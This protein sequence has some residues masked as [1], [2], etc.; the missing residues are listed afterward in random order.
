MF[1]SARYYRPSPPLRGFVLKIQKIS[2]KIL[3][4][5]PYL[6]T[7]N[8]NTGIGPKMDQRIIDKL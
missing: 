8:P 1:I 6:P 4:N 5:T 3:I 2:E 7:L